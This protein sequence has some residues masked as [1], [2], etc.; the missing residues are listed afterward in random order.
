[1][2]QGVVICPS[3]LSHATVRSLHLHRR[4]LHPL[5]H[6]QDR[7]HIPHIHK[8]TPTLPPRSMASLLTFLTRWKLICRGMERSGAVFDFG[9]GMGEGE[10]EDVE[11][12]VV[13]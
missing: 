3:M 4:N 13:D 11:V 6:V 1:M 12:E 9:F 5:P 2:V 7:L 8:P 10:G